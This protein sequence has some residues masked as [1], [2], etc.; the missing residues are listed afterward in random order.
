MIAAAIDIGANSTRLFIASIKNNQVIPLKREMVIT[1]LGKGLKNSGLILDENFKNTIKVI[2]RYK[3]E[4]VEYGVEIIKA[5]GTSALRRAINA[6][7]FVNEVFKKTNIRVEIISSDVEAQLSFTGAIKSIKQSQIPGCFNFN[8]NKDVLVID[9]G[10]GSSELI[11]GNIKGEV[12]EIK[13]IGIGCVKISEQFIKNNPPTKSEI[14]NMV[15][16]IRERLL[17]ELKFDNKDK[18]SKKIRMIGLAGTISSIASMYLGLT[19]YEMEKLNYLCLKLSSITRIF[20]N[21]CKLDLQNRKKV[22][23]LEP[24]RA[25]VIIGGSAIVIELMRFFNKRKLIVSEHDILD[26]IIYSLADF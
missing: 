12:K 1:R 8:K 25:D 20:K 26:G 19:K 21:L 15:N 4:C 22:I 10:G 18:I 13:S 9:I 3:R 2:E 17:K 5:V 14:D 6:K 24:D 11:F 23:G 7:D 16:Y